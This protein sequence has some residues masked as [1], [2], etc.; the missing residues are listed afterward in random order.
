MYVKSKN[1]MQNF[2][3]LNLEDRIRKELIVRTNIDSSIE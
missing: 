3:I 1:E 2:T